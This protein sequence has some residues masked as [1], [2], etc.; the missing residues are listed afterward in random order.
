MEI[1]VL[2]CM[3][4][5]GRCDKF[6]SVSSVSAIK[7]IDKKLTFIPV[8]FILLRVWGTVQF[9]Y[10]SG[11]AHLTYLGC[12]PKHFATGFTLLAYI[13]VHITSVVTI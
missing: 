3:N 1:I 4:Q 13:Q 5:Q 11:V 10:S 8:I 7:R 12:A 2:S 6:M 9:F